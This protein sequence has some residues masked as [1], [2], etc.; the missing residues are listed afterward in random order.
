MRAERTPQLR[1]RL[2]SEDVVMY[3]ENVTNLVKRP[4]FALPEEKKV[5][6][7]MHLIR[8]FRAASCASGQNHLGVHGRGWK[9]AYGAESR[10]ALS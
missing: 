10:H 5:L 7:F 9:K 3:E 1:A 4:H 8:E 2:P 6:Y